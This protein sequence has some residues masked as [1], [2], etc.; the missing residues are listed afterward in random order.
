MKKKF[1]NLI[2]SKKNKISNENNNIF[3][4]R[5]LFEENRKTNKNFEIYKYHWIDEKKRLQ[6]FSYIKKIYN[7]VLN[8]LVPALN[9]F[10]SK[11]F[12][13]K[14]WELI[15]FYF[16]SS[17]I[18][19]AY[20]RWITIKNIRKKYKLKK[21]EIFKYKKNRIIA[22]DTEEFLKMLK[23]DDWN[24]WMVSEV[25]KFNNLKC[26]ERKINKIILKKKIKENINYIKF[27]NFFFPKN[28]NKIFLKSLNLSKTLKIGLNFKLKQFNITSLMNSFSLTSG[29]LIIS[30]CNQISEKR[31]IFD[32]IK[33]KDKFESFI[34]K[35]LPKVFPTCFFENFKR[36]DENIKYLNWP[37]NPNII[38]TG[39]DHL[40]NEPFKVFSANKMLKGSKL[41]LLQHGHSGHHDFSGIYYENRVCDK[42]FSWGNNT[43]KKEYSPLFV[44]STIGEKIK[45]INPKGILLSFHEFRLSPWKQGFYPREINTV[46]IFKK[47]FFSFL[48][49]LDKNT[50][51]NVTTKCYPMDGLNY[52]SKDLL[53]KF[54]E[55]KYTTTDKK[56]K[57]FELS[58]NYNLLIET[59]NSSGFLESLSM[60]I[61][62][63]LITPK[64]FFVV[65]KEY[66]KYYDSLIKNNII[67]FDTTK[68]AKFVNSNLTNIDKWW[69]NKKRQASIKYFCENMCRYEGSIIK[70]IN[71]I[72]EK[73]KN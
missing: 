5:W 59:I 52:I 18:F 17:Y 4:G 35:T 60:N 43:I 44:T 64:K 72:A 34:Y 63:I 28:Y 66:K 30:R 46:D 47:N 29:N 23:T 54:K 49:N 8:N 6:D 14:H 22:H 16:L 12:K 33:T 20:D 7:K 62:V 68:A 41:Y 1:F 31:R 26:Y 21:I 19:F 9:S 61:P 53:K 37:N 55:I 42:Y 27:F 40:V 51:K 48:N 71:K 15:I 69:F 50:I 65:K 36:I 45:K 10:N 11:K 57:G 25:I 39:F 3:T 73:L 2:F 56:R 24:D 70:S 58:G 32:Q 67:F 13:T 38:F